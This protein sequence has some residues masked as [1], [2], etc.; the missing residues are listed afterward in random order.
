MSKTIPRYE[1]FCQ[2]IGCNYYH[3]VA[4][5]ESKPFE[6]LSDLERKQLEYTK[7][8]CKERCTKTSYQF[9]NWLK[10]KRLT[11]LTSNLD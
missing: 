9:Y 7:R 10:K 6:M 3:F 11:D 5:L 2:D 8:I 4:R 1:H